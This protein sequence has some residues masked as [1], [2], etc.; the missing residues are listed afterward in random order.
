MRNKGEQK[1]EAEVRQL[2]MVRGALSIY[3]CLTAWGV[4]RC[5]KFGG[6][7]LAKR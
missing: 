7:V 1:E 5:R 3:L 2:H 4:Q 6:V